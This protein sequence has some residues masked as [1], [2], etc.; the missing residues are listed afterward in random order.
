MKRVPSFKGRNPVS[1]KSSIVKSK[2]KSKATR[3]EMLLRRELR[4]L[5]LRFKTNVNSLPGKPD[6]VFAD[7]KLAVFCDGDFWHG[8]N[9]RTLKKRLQ[10]TRNRKYW[11]SKIEYNRQRDKRILTK[12]RSQRWKVIRIWESNIVAHPGEIARRILKTYRD[13]ECQ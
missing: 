2:N 12:L 5:G 6:I 8:R 7:K 11:I 13:L 4:K 3:H 10:K 1:E 9:W